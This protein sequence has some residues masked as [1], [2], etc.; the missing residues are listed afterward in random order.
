MAGSRSE[1]DAGLMLFEIARLPSWGVE[2]IS[3]SS[4]WGQGKTPAGVKA[5]RAAASTDIKTM[6]DIVSSHSNANRQR[7]HKTEAFYQLIR[8]VYLYRDEETSP[9]ELIDEFCLKYLDAEDRKI[10]PGA[11]KVNTHSLLSAVKSLI[12]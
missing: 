3:Y 7:A 12:I 2:G 5:I 4:L 8:N 11:A 9:K 6:F 10:L 1:Y